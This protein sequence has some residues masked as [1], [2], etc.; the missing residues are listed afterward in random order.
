MSS[1]PV[2]PLPASAKK[3]KI[4]IA[5]TNQQQ[6]QQQETNNK[7][8]L[9]TSPIP[10]PP[11]I[12]LD[13]I[14]TEQPKI[15]KKSLT[16][17]RKS[18]ISD[19]R[20]SKAFSLGPE[21]GPLLDPET[22]ASI[23]Q[24][25]NN[26]NN[27]HHTNQEIIETQTTIS[28]TQRDPTK[29][30][31]P[32]SKKIF[33]AKSQNQLK[34]NETSSVTTPSSKI[35]TNQKSSVTDDLKAISSYLAGS[36]NEEDEEE[37]KS[38]QY[39][40]KSSAR[41][42]ATTKQIVKTAKVHKETPARRKKQSESLVQIENNKEN[43]TTTSNNNNKLGRK[44]SK[45]VLIENNQTT[46]T[47]NV[48]ETIYENKELDTSL[49]INSTITLSNEN[50]TSKQQGISGSALSDETY[51]IANT[52]KRH[53]LNSTDSS[54]L[55]IDTSSSSNTSLIRADSPPLPSTSANGGGLG[56]KRETRKKQVSYKEV[57][58]NVKMRCDK[59]EKVW[60]NK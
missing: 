46:T 35:S 20:R 39:E 6:S 26:N 3:S 41:K 49:V 10:L 12:E 56:S 19:R 15:S 27:H 21:T 51:I 25:T 30:P 23:E 29:P 4:T 42:K 54:T 7:S 48:P 31:L 33:K 57:S 60:L 44:A 8:I 37:D 1:Q 52:N 36:D 45:P 2:A 53:R 59:N 17:Q 18:S 38:D 28:T 40:P 50:E 9:K 32:V 47:S 22:I 58:L 14:N 43:V 13:E 16:N 11:S 55:S 34:S 5:K 24:E